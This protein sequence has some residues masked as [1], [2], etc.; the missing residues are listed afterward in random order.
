MIRN[1][2][3]ILFGV[4]S[5]TDWVFTSQESRQSP[6]CLGAPEFLTL[7]RYEAHPHLLADDHVLIR[8]GLKALFEKQEF[9]VEGE[10]S[11][12]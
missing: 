12:G 9:Q 4:S 6:N 11:D 2:N 3:E 5:P 10:A 1:C 7:P 8:Q